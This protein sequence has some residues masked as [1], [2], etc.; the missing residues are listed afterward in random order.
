MNAKLIMGSLILVVHNVCFAGLFGP[1]NYEECVVDKM[2]GQ[3]LQMRWMVEEAC[4]IA[5]PYEKNITDYM[6]GKDQSDLISYDGFTLKNDDLLV[7]DLINKSKYKI[8]TGIYALSLL[9]CGEANV[10]DK[11][12]RVPLTPTSRDNSKL[13]GKVSTNYKNSKCGKL[14]EL[15]GKRIR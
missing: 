5:Y 2:K 12:E 14:L 8:T 11:S 15:N 13:I 9:E 6:G 4:E 10:F 3:V 1:S 7:L